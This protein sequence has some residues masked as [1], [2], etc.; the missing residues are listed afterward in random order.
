MKASKYTYI[1]IFITITIVATIGLQT[2]WNLKNYEENKRSLINE[3]QIAFDNSIEYYYVEDSKNN[4]LAF[5]DDNKDSVSGAGQLIDKIR[6]DTVFKNIPR[7][8]K[9]INANIDINDKKESTTS[10]TTSVEYKEMGTSANPKYPNGLSSTTSFTD[11]TKL[12]TRVVVASS[13]LKPSGISSIKVFKGKKSLDSISKIKSIA[14]KIMISLVKDSIEFKKLSRAF[15]KELK[16][17]NINVSYAIEHYKSD[18]LFDK[19]HGPVSEPLSLQTYSKSTYLPESQKLK[20]SFSDPT[21]LI[22]KRSMTEIILSLLLS[23]SIIVCLLYLFT[24]I[25]RQKKIDEIKNDLISNITHEFKTPITTISTAIEGIKNFNQ[26]NDT[27]KTNRYLNISSQQLSKLGIMVEKL[28]ETASLDT[29]QLVLR[30]EAVNLVELLKSNIEKHQLICPE[31]KIIFTTNQDILILNVDLFHFEN[32]ISNLIDNAVKYGGD[33]ISITLNAPYS[34]LISDNGT[35]IDKHHREKIFDQFYRIPKGNIHDIKGFGI[36][37]YYSRK[38]IQK[39]G[40]KL[41]LMPDTK[42]TVFKV[43]LPHER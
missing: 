37:L 35:G 42:T 34:L 33:L 8:R 28:L 7:N 18:K 2:Y 19:S 14:N 38:I 20:L 32:A 1:I 24:T 36:G 21:V 4:F 13:Y 27:E 31:K 23:L 9:P 12:Q 22:L 5:I 39:H 40:G 41:E 30:R 43:S 3:V 11:S 29:D 17:K 25:N 16:R 15:N 10:I 6:L 26:T